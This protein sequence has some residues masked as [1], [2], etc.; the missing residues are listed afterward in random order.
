MSEKMVRR[1]LLL[2]AEEKEWC[3]L[4]ALRL[5]AKEQKQVSGNEVIRRLIKKAMKKKK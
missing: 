2:N 5:T 1:D 4:E 3:R